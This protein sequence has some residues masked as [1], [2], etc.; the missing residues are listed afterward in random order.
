[1]IRNKI[2]SALSFVNNIECGY[3]VKIVSNEIVILS[4]DH[5][6]VKTYEPQTNKYKLKIVDATKSVQLLCT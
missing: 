6:H 5:M 1:M 4:Y 2:C 3:T